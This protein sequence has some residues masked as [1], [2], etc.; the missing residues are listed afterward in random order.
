MAIATT[1]RVIASFGA[2]EV[3]FYSKRLPAATSKAPG[4]TGLTNG[5]THD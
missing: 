5:E 3:T 1:L 2:G 4:Q